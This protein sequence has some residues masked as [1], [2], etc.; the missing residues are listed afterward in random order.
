[1]ADQADDSKEAQRREPRRPAGRSGCEGTR[2]RSEQDVHGN[3]KGRMRATL[4]QNWKYEL[5]KF[6]RELGTLERGPPRGAGARDRSSTRAG[7]VK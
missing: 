5:M 4:K 7:G 2:A 3:G 6:Q 1:M